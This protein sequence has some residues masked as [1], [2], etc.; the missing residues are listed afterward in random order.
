[1]TR[2]RA[3]IAASVCVV[4]GAASPASAATTVRVV[5][6]PKLQGWTVVNDSVTSDVPTSTWS[7]VS[8]P[9][10]PTRG[11]GSMDL[12]VGSDGASQV[13]LSMKP[14]RPLD[15]LMS[16]SFGTVR[17]DGDCYPVFSLVVHGADATEAT[18]EY[19]PVSAVTGTWRSVAPLPGTDGGAWIPQAPS[20]FQTAHGATTIKGIKVTIGG[21]DNGACQFG[22]AAIDAIRLAW[23][24][25][26]VI[27]D[28]EPPA[29]RISDASIVEGN[30]GTRVLSFTVKLAATTD[31]VTVRYATRNG[32]A[33]A[34][35]DFAAASGTVTIGS[36][37]TSATV[38]VTIKG[39]KK[40]EPTERFTVQL[41]KPKNA[42]IVDATA[43]GTI[44]NDD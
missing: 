10:T 37:L 35:G 28:L 12:S 24:D 36:G 13:G 18:L 23:D 38:S 11:I 25:G 3:V 17:P 8:G 44:R 27:Y 14:D 19:S 30:Q 4:L 21:Y 20:A 43:T 39:D 31:T 41:T 40:V 1:M 16:A 9:S 6:P 7:F 33:A 29:M 42:R 5:S 26:T 15:E 32:T 34:P 2:L 22:H